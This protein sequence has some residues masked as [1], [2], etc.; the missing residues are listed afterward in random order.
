MVFTHKGHDLVVGV[1]LVKVGELSGGVLVSFDESG[2]C[3]S[4]ASSV[5]GEQS[6]IVLP[7]EI[8]DGLKRHPAFKHPVIFVVDGFQEGAFG[9]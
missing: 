2:A 4:F 5:D 7:G 8:K 6:A 9:E 3:R 1:M